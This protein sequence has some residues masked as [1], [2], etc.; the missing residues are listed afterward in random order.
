MA[1]A[2]KALCL[3]LALGWILGVHR[4]Y[5]ALWEED[6]AQPHTVYPYKAALLPPQE[7]R[8]L[9]AGIP[10]QDEAQLRSL[11]MDYFS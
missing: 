2:R 11:L 9:E 3:W 8:R 6:A 10:I 7:E 4:G 5:I 1:S